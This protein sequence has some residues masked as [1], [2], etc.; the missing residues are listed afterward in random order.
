MDDLLDL[1]FTSPSSTPNHSFRPSS[2]KPSTSL[3]FDNLSKPAGIPNY[4]S[5]TG[6]SPLPSRSHTPQTAPVP[7]LARLGQPPRPTSG[8]GDRAAKPSTPAL[9]PPTDAF[10]SLLSLGPS[11]GSNG[12]ESMAERARR[13]DQEKRDKEEREKKQFDNGDFWDKFGGGPASQPARSLGDASK[14]T[15]W[16]MEASLSSPKPSST[17]SRASLAP[18]APQ[19]ISSR[20]TAPIDPFDFDLLGG[21]PSTSSTSS[22]HTAI[23]PRNGASSPARGGGDDDVLGDLARPTPTANTSS[24]PPRVTTRP[25]S[26]PP[27]IVGQIVEMGFSAAQ[28]RA[29]LAKTPSGLDVSA[30]LEL[31]LGAGTTSQAQDTGSSRD[32]PP[33]DEDEEEEDFIQREREQREEAERERRRARR[34]GPSRDA[35]SAR[36]KD[37]IRSAHTSGRGTPELGEQAEKYLAQAS[38]IGT[39]VLSKATSLW[40]TGKEKA[41]KLYE[42]QKRAYEA[43]QA[44]KEAGEARSGREARTGGREVRDGRPR[45]MV[46]AEASG[47]EGEERE[48][49]AGGGF[50]DD[51]DSEEELPAPPSPPQETYRS[52]RERAD[53]LFAEETQPYVPASRRKTPTPSAPTSVPSR[54]ARAVT[55]A[56]PVLVQRQLVPASSTAVERAAAAK[57]KGN[58]HFKLGRFSE[59][60][61]SYTSAISS[62]PEGHLHLVALH[63]NRAASRLKLGQSDGAIED[64]GI[65]LAIIGPSYHPFKEA[66]LPPEYADVKLAESMGKALIKRAQAYEMGEKWKKALEDWEKVMGLDAVFLGAGT[67]GQGTKNMA[68]EGARRARQMLDGGEPIKAAPRPNGNA[69]RVPPKPALKPAARSAPSTS[70]PS[71]AVKELRQANAAQEKE[72]AERLRLKDAVES[73]LLAWKSGKETNLR[74]LIASLDTVLWE[75]IMGGVKVGMH[76]LIT[77]KQVKIRYMKVI[78]RLHPDKLD[79][80]STTVEQRMLANGAFGTLNEA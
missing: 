59:S 51:D 23:G 42:E 66:Q 8:S 27:H 20:T 39:S 62:L 18:H 19:Q 12:K 26:P 78:A 47:A 7:Q 10:S 16:D 41:Q 80:K 58:G 38:E 50:R 55:S 25:S 60:Q 13:L 22:H 29:A 65:V 79:V 30:A 49:G 2:A 4:Y 36:S 77:E 6:I 54:P 34:A 14:G 3:A 21:G 24:R 5:G 46:D 63:N 53:L 43:Q 69:A 72:D 33:E 44:A 61:S 9:Q 17:S 68:A 71:T 75:G 73:K 15:F 37:E 31:L 48:E 70:A 28:A 76:E 40:A 32:H 1:N 52:V 67:A 11:S 56:P 35:I 57:A 45:W 74:A 64:C